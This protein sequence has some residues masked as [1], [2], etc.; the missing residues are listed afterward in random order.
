[1][2]RDGKQTKY[3][4]GFSFN[5]YRNGELHTWKANG[6]GIEII[7]HSG[8]QEKTKTWMALWPA[9]KL[10]VVLMS[11]SKYANPRRLAGRLLEVVMQQDSKQS[12]E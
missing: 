12:D 7:G 4:L 11:N 2:T 6:T 9:K 10:G 5:H 1:M 8:S 3:A